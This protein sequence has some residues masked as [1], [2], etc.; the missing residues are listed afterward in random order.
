MVI[1]SSKFN[2]KESLEWAVQKYME[3]YRTEVI[4]AVTEVVPEVAKEAVQKLKKASP[5]RPGGGK[6]AKGWTYQVDKGRL[7]VG[8]T[9]YGKSGTYQLA[10]LLEFGHARRGGG[11][12]VPPSPPGGHIKPVEEWV[13]DEI[14]NRT[15]ERLEA[16]P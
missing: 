16:I 5:R 11:R 3:N 4:E 2:S 14:V 8:A 7:S 9:I 15:I 13:N 10:H 12:D 1:N 6:Y